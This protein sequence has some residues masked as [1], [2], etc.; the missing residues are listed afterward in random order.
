MKIFFYIS[1]LALIVAVA[2]GILQLTN[3]STT[4]LFLYLQF[5]LGCWHLLSSLIAIAKFGTRY[6]WFV[7]HLIVCL[8]YMG[9]LAMGSLQ[10]SF[11]DKFL[12]LVVIIIPWSIAL[13]HT[14]QLY[15]LPK[16]ARTSILDL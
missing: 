5:A 16:L 11:S 7:L 4:F 12:L 2:L 6:R 3:Y 13:I 1:L 8:L 9:L 10:V 14:I 15:R